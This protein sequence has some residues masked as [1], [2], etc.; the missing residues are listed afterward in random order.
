MLG[1]LILFGLVF[2]T[3]YGWS[4]FD[5]TDKS[6]VKNKLENSVDYAY[7][8][9]AAKPFKECKDKYASICQKALEI[10]YDKFCYT[11][12][13]EGYNVYCKRTCGHCPA[14]SPLSCH[15]STKG[16]CWDNI[17][18]VSSGCPDCMDRTSTCRK[19][20]SMCN[21]AHL[22]RACPQTCKICPAN[23][24]C[25]DDPHQAEW[26][27]Y[28]KEAD[29]CQI[30]K[31]LM[32]QYC[33]KTCNLCPPLSGKALGNKVVE[34]FRKGTAEMLDLPK[35]KRLESEAEL[36]NILLKD[37]EKRK[38]I[39][40]QSNQ[41]LVHQKKSIDDAEDEDEDKIRV[42]EKDSMSNEA[43]DALAKLITA[44]S[45]GEKRSITG[46]ESSDALAKLVTEEMAIKKSQLKKKDVANK[47]SEE[48]FKALVKLMVSDSTNQKREVAKTK[49]VMSSESFNALNRLLTK[50]RDSKKTE[51]KKEYT[52]AQSLD[53]L[54]RLLHQNSKKEASQQTPPA[55]TQTLEALLEA[56]NKKEVSEKKKTVT[57]NEIDQLIKLL[58]AD[59]K[60]AKKSVNDVDQQKKEAD[61]VLIQLIFKDVTEKDSGD[62]NKKSFQVK[63]Q[64]E[65]K[66]RDQKTI[67]D[68]LFKMI[69]AE[70]LN[71]K[72]HIEV[73]PAVA[74]P[75]K[76]EN[77]DSAKTAKS[78]ESAENRKEMTIAKKQEA[79]D[80][81]VDLVKKNKREKELLDGGSTA[82]EEQLIRLLKERSLIKDKK[83]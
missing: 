37:D 19:I 2:T 13:F 38:T 22:A 44:K 3:A 18:K 75:V 79:M 49:K 4:T 82:V 56:V 33:P 7:Y 71:A 31:E 62:E 76:K 12:E 63:N 6:Y 52:A 77:A 32:T 66:K 55:T 41:I 35:D 51:T 1:K 50:Q 15:A 39:D 42:V 57:D 83:A 78:A 45:S 70:G 26:C 5:K 25:N 17:T 72:T 61:K 23:P 48:S 60:I 47:M 29:M 54:N 34:V 67:D 10:G 30:D 16:C 59:S 21:Q 58:T 81:L 65:K 28:W 73:V 43:F 14:V 46:S 53:A 69:Q 64:D 9:N 8:K 36:L 20:A 27:P 40:S 68:V 74:E 11:Q 24:Y 80:H